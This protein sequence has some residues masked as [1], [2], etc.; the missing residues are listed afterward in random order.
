MPDWKPA[1]Q[2]ATLNPQGK[3]A[4]AG[5][6]EIVFPSGVKRYYTRV[7]LHRNAL[8]LFHRRVLRTN[9]DEPLNDVINK[10]PDQ[11]AGVFYFGGLAAYAFSASAMASQT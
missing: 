1:L 6:T 7:R 3:R 11:E 2:F 8:T 4:R 9:P 5:A 10:K